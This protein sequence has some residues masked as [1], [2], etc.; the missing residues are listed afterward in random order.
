MA[1]VVHCTVND[2]QFWGEGNYCMANAILVTSGTPRIRGRGEPPDKF[3]DN[4][5]QIG[6]TPIQDIGD[7]YC[8]TFIKKPTPE[9][10]SHPPM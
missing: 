7:S 5:P 4:S 2:C 10:L 1:T 8:Y 3:G 6:E 9:A